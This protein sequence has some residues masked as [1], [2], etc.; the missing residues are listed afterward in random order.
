MCNGS[1]SYGL[2]VDSGIEEL[3]F[4]AIGCFSCVKEERKGYFELGDSSFGSY[5]CWR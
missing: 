3:N 5:D 4:L 2:F 1:G